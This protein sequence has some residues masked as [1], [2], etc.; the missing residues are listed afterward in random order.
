MIFARRVLRFFDA[1]LEVDFLRA[2]ISLLIKNYLSQSGEK[3]RDIIS[4]ENRR[5]SFL[6]TQ[7]LPLIKGQSFG[8]AHE[9][10]ASGGEQ[11]LGFCGFDVQSR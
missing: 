9:I 1:E 11:G 7:P 6:F 8:A 10:Y 2:M 5:M 3:M 4:C